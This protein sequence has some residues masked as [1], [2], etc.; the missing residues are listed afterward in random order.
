MAGPLDVFIPAYDARERFQLTVHAPASLVYR[1]AVQFDLESVSLVRAIFRLRARFL[2]STPNS[3]TP[4][5]RGFLVSAKSLG[6]GV[7]REEPGRLFVAG[8]HCQPWL[9]DVVFTPLAPHTF[10]P[11]ASPGEV[12]IAWT[13]EVESLDQVHSILATETRAIATDSSART[14]FK[15][16]WRWARFGI[17]PIRWFLLPAI[18]KQAQACYDS[19]GAPGSL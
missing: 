14:R 3:A 9:A 5:K 6:W 10:R 2:D 8:A 16:Y 13:L 15:R 17:Y 4:D 19:R 18:R 11:F 7:L 12:K 1:T